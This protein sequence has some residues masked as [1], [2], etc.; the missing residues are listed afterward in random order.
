MDVEHKIEMSRSSVSP[1]GGARDP[2]QGLPGGANA[3]YRGR[4]AVDAVEL[5]R[6]P[7]C[8]AGGRGLPEEIDSSTRSRAP[9][10]TA[11]RSPSSVHFSS[12]A[13]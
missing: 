9:L 10:L 11:R 6:V 5:A 7:G 2:F 13:R 4:V 8:R 1:S 3:Q 12:R